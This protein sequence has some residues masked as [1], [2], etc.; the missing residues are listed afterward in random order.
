MIQVSV[1]EPPSPREEVIEILA[2]GLC[3]LVIRGW[4]PEQPR[5]EH[6]SVVGGRKRHRDLVGNRQPAQ[7]AYRQPAATHANIDTRTV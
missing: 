7:H 5:D 3:E 4:K 2:Q 1:P 6:H